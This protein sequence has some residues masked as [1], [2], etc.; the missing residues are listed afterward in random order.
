[1]SGGIKKKSTLRNKSAKRS[2][3]SNKI[4]EFR[5]ETGGEEFHENPLLKLSK[6]TKKE[7]QQNKSA[8]FALSVLNK[9][10]FNTSNNISKSSLRRRKRKEKEQLKPNMQELLTSLP[11]AKDGDDLFSSNTTTIKSAKSSEGFVKSSKLNKN[12]PNATKKSGHQQILREEHK[13]FSN[14]LKNPAFRQSPFDALKS[15]I[16][17]NMQK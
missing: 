12:L 6:I 9:T 3:L 14:V 13:N 2:N 4:S 5:Q 7:K 10:T 8:S 16:Q 1:M 15:A 11:G 17:Q